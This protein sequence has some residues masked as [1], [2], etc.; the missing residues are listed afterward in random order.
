MLL[1]FELFSKYQNFYGSHCRPGYAID[2]VYPCLWMDL[3]GV[4][5]RTLVKCFNSGVLLFPLKGIHVPFT[6]QFAPHYSG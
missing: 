5:K 1:G 6:S 2:E 3:E 4:S